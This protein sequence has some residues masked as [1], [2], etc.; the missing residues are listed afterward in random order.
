M[1]NFIDSLVIEYENIVEK[2]DVLTA[3]MDW[4]TYYELPGRERERL[5]KQR[6]AMLEYAVIL[7]ERIKFHKEKNHE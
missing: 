2:I 7:G 6:N 1:Q 4:N 3:T 5:A